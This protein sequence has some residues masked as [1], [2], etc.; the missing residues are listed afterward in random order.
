[1]VELGAIPIFHLP[2]EAS[3]KRAKL[4][5]SLRAEGRFGT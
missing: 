4:P 2:W 5:L 1:M 3:A